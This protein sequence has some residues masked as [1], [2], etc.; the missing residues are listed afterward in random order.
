MGISNQKVRRGTATVVWTAVALCILIG[1]RASL[2]GAVTKQTMSSKTTSRYLGHGTHAPTQRPSTE[3]SQPSQPSDPQSELP[4]SAPSSLPSSTPSVLQSQ[5]PSDLPSQIPSYVPSKVPSPKPTPVPSK[6]PTSYPTAAPSASPSASPSFA[7]SSAPS[8]VPSQLPTLTPSETPSSSPTSVPS[9]TPSDTPSL[10]PSTTPVAPTQAQTKIK[11]L[12]DSDGV[13]G[14]DTVSMFE[15][16]CSEE[17]LP[18]S[19]PTIYPAEYSEFECKVVR[20]TLL[21]GNTRARLL[22]E[23]GKIIL[24]TEAVAIEIE[25]SADIDPPPVH[26]DDLVES[27]FATYISEFQQ[28]LSSKDAYFTSAGDTNPVFAQQPNDETP[29][30]E[31]PT[32][33]FII[34][35]VVFAFIVVSTLSIMFL[36]KNRRRNEGLHLRTIDEVANGIEVYTPGEMGTQRKHKPSLFVETSFS[37]DSSIYGPKELE[38]IENDSEMSKKSQISSKYHNSQ[39][40]HD[41]Y[42]PRSVDSSKAR[43]SGLDNS[44]LGDRQEDPNFSS[45][46]SDTYNGYQY[47]SS[48]Y[49][50]TDSLEGQSNVGEEMAYQSHV[51][52]RDRADSISTRTRS[53]LGDITSSQSDDMETTTKPRS[54]KLPFFGRGILSGL[55]TGAGRSVATKGTSEVRGEASRQQSSIV[56]DCVDGT[57]ANKETSKPKPWYKKGQRHL[58]IYDDEAFD[59]TNSD[60]V[61]ED[62]SCL[63]SERK[64]RLKDTADVG[65][66]TPKTENRGKYHKSPGNVL[67][68]QYGF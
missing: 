1:D 41:S 32:L 16:V 25:A 8:T 18:I 52:M 45:I 26:F 53:S 49:D 47:S 43:L 44:M 37:G 2:V 3:P 58:N 64:D 5:V 46:N 62:L 61:L 36:V 31:I 67:Y 21:S 10:M 66:T 27:T 30:N 12:S 56:A 6:M 63:E 15:Q 24:F 29:G 14:T 55:K 22:S 51:H 38:T 7:P 19:M 50:E 20:Q 13:M 57:D 35:G 65:A 39:A 17:F 9:L 28:M 11:L 48:F 42:T 34:G 33:Y 68:N 4:S 54:N 40:G 60:E 23:K 59:A